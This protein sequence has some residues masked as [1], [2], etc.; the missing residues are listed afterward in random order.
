MRLSGSNSSLRFRFAIF[1]PILAPA[2]V[3][4]L[5]FAQTHDHETAVLRPANTP[6]RA[7]SRP[8][9]AQPQVKGRSAAAVLRN[10]NEL[11]QAGDIPALSWV[12]ATAGPSHKPTFEATVSAIRMDNKAAVIARGN[13]PSKNKARATAATKFLADLSRQQH[14]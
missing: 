2:A 4:I 10:V 8:A 13:A 3:L 6:G 9:F 5:L 1:V 14:T 7:D 12:L 11:S